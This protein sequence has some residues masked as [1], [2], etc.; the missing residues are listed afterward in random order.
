MKDEIKKLAQQIKQHKEL[1]YLGKPKISDA[2]FDKLEDHLKKIAPDHPILSMVGASTQHKQKI[3][4]KTKMLSLMKTYELEDLESW[5][6]ERDVVSTYKIDGVSCSLIYEKG[7]LH[8]AK[9]RGDGSFGEDILEK[10]L[11]INSIPNHISSELL[12]FEV[13]G[14]IFCTEAQFIH[15]AQ[16][17]QELNLE[18]PTSQR[19][20]VAGLMGRKDS[21]SLC[22]FLNFKAVDL[23]T[24]DIKI[25][26]EREKYS[27]LK[28]MS[29]DIPELTWHKAKES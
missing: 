10:I 28:K 27:Y 8:L 20:I 16:K 26:T 19:N 24:D 13:R 18:K 7:F 21:F 6:E 11:W 23:I 9:T 29:F 17:M 22:T 2:D 14:E 4:H 1:Y 3:A 12:N 15:L 25:K 5:R